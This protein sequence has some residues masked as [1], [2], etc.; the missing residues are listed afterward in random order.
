MPFDGTPPRDDRP[1]RH[2][3]KPT[4]PYEKRRAKLFRDAGLQVLQRVKRNKHWNQAV[5]RHFITYYKLIVAGLDLQGPPLAESSE[6]RK[7]ACRR[8]FLAITERRAPT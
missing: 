6:R 5:R 2:R 8:A 7:P 4:A 1:E 3:R